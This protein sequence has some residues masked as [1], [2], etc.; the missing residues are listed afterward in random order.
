MVFAKMPILRTMVFTEYW[1]GI[2]GGCR[3][4]LAPSPFTKEMPGCRWERVCRGRYG[5]LVG[6]DLNAGNQVRRCA[7]LSLPNPN[8]RLGQSALDSI[9]RNQG[10]ERAWLSFDP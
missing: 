6:N 3:S 8:R 10:I 1:M 4:S 2:T 9:V 7:A 5:N